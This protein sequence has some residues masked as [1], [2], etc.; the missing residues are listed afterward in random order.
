MKV[1]FCGVRGSI[2]SPG[3]KTVKYGGNTT[4]ISVETDGQYNI[5][6]DAG[7]GINQLGQSLLSKLPVKCALFITHTHWDHINGLPFFVPLFIPGNTINIFGAFEPVYKKSIGEI[8]SNQ[9]VY[10]YFPVREAELKATIKYITL[11]E[12]QSVKVGDAKVTSVLMNHPILNFGYKVEYKGKSMFF[13]GDHEPPYNIYNSGDEYYN[14]YN[15]LIEQKNQVILD[16]ISGVDI[17]IADSAYTTEDYKM[18]KG[19]GHGTFDSCVDMATKAGVKKLY[20]THHEP[21]R[22]DDELE[23]I[24]KEVLNKYKDCGV[25]LHLA[26]EGLEIEL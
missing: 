22:S 6:I 14:E 8:L 18:K 15:N 7:T 25:E 4:C 23:G 2:P 21:M 13:T 26:Q 10:Y 9:L 16:F 20:F 5:V 19:W 3:P 17:F 12:K 24:Y 1:K 11:K